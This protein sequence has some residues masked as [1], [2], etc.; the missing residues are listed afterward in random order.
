VLLHTASCIGNGCP[1]GTQARYT[2]SPV[3]PIVGVRNRTGF[4]ACDPCPANHASEGGCSANSCKEC[5][6]PAFVPTFDNARCGEQGLAA[7]TNMCTSRQVLCAS[8]RATTVIGDGRWRCYLCCR[9]LVVPV[10]HVS[11]APVRMSH[12]AFCMPFNMPNALHVTSH[13]I[14]CC[15]VCSWERRLWMLPV[16]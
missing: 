1:A 16:P 9:A 4:L 3:Q 8:V 15:S 5:V 12:A 10:L 6:A 7:A 11:A 14:V 13:F 2:W